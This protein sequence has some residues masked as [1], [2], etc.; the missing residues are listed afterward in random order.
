MSDP[1]PASR[2][3]F[4]K[5]GTCKDRRTMIILKLNKLFKSI[6]ISLHTQLSWQDG[7]FFDLLAS[8]WSLSL[9]LRLPLDL[10]ISRSK[11]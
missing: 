1:E 6:H 2:T 3:T 4:R 10:Y 9:T 5:A 8:A 11:L 7:S